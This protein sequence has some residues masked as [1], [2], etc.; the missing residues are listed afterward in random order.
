MKKST[1]YRETIRQHRLLLSVPV[2][3]AVAIAAWL[4]LSAPK[5]YVSSTSLWIDNSGPA[6]S[7]LGNPNPALVQPSA[8]E[9]N[10]LVELLSTKSFA[11][12]VARKSSLGRYLTHSSA[13]LTRAA[14]LR[15][16]GSLTLRVLAAVGP[17]KVTTAVPGP[18]VL[19][20][21][22]SGPTR[23]VATSTLQA[24]VTELQ[25][26]TDRLSR[27]YSDSAV[28]Y[29]ATDVQQANQALVLARNQLSNYQSQHPNASPNDPNLT[30]L[31][32]A[33]TT[34]STALTTAKESL[35]NATAAAGAN[36]NGLIVQTIDAPSIP[37]APTTG[38]KRD[39]E[40]I[41]GGLLGGLLISFLGVL[42]LTRRTSDPWED[43]LAAAGEAPAKRARSASATATSTNGATATNGASARQRKAPRSSMPVP[44]DKPAPPGSDGS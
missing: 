44:I 38:K 14:L 16:G 21:N 25:S 2:V 15:G 24:I 10:V 29:Y 32:T 6:V 17:K 43:E 23:A 26:T 5:S 31:T 42:A 7:S 20:I 27:A 11:L 30:A 33:V 4:V 8:V 12:S 22:F 3:L 19:Q 34:A 18:Q 36:A 35:D 37:L 41:A 39:L 40:G 13:G 9:Q 28:S 1:S